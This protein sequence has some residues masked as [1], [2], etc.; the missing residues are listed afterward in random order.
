MNSA[1][2]FNSLA[3]DYTVGRLDYADVFVESL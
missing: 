2:R 1:Q 3:N